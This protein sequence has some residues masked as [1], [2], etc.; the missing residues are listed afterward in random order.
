M[1]VKCRG[2]MI[3]IALGL[4]NDGCSDMVGLAGT[5]S[6]L[7]AVSR[8]GA[9][10]RVESTTVGARPRKPMSRMTMPADG[11]GVGNDTLA[12]N[13]FSLM[14]ESIHANSW[15]TYSKDFKAWVV[16]RTARSEPLFIEDDVSLQDRQNAVIDF[17]VYHSYT[18][19]Y[20]PNTLWVWIYAMRFMHQL[21]ER[22]LDLVPMRRLKMVEHGWK[23]I[24]GAPHRKIPV[25]P[26]L[27]REVYL[28]GGLDM[29]RWNDLMVML[30]IVLA[31]SFLWRSC[32]YA[33]ENGRIDRDKCLRV[34][35]GLFS[36]EGQDA[37]LAAPAPI[38]EFTVFHRTSK[39]DFLHQGASN[40]IFADPNGV[41]W[42]PV[43]L[44][45]KARALW[46]SSFGEAGAAALPGA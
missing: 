14:M 43:A 25:T 35:D 46:S 6:R 34:R 5:C 20:A 27:I 19:N 21:Y 28:N 37:S 4:L 11:R 10:K 41:P 7:H 9:P 3:M 16:W 39:A 1:S 13:K 18:C 29:G 30:A 38:Q 31:F 15:N 45:N 22:D 12:V 2:M 23:R 24:Y 32:E 33:Q 8:C 42:C 40:N 26:Q 44:L 17:Y 36:L